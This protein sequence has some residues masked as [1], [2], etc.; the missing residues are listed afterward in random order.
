LIADLPAASTVLV[1]FEYEPDTAAE[2]QPLAEALLNHLAR[3]NDITV[4]ALS[5][6]PTGAAMAQSAMAALERT[7]SSWVNVGYISGGPTGISALMTGALPG[8]ASPLQTDYRGKTLNTQAARLPDLEPGLIIVLAARSEHLRAWIEQAGTPL[9]TP[10]LAAVSAGASPLAYPYEQS[11][12]LV[13]VLSG[14]NDAVAYNALEGGSG[15]DELIT[16][17]NAQGIGGTAAAMLI[18]IGGVVYGL[19]A[20]RQQQEQV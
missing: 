2:M 13:A 18:L 3:R 14:I 1:A 7:P 19:R 6:R 8:F 9:Q 15:E 4:L 5:T 16:T 17:W 10:V 20:L 12:Q 11:G